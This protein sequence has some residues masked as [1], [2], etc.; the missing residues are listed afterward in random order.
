MELFDKRKVILIRVVFRFHFIIIQRRIM[1]YKWKFLIFITRT[2]GLFWKHNITLMLSDYKCIVISSIHAEWL[3]LISRNITDTYIYIYTF[4]F[5]YKCFKKNTFARL[6][7]VYMF[8][9]IIN[10]FLTRAESF[11]FVMRLIWPA[12]MILILINSKRMRIFFFFYRNF[13]ELRKKRAKYLIIHESRGVYSEEKTGKKIIINIIY[14]FLSDA[15]YR[16]KNKKL[17]LFSETKVH[18]YCLRFVGM[19]KRAGDIIRR[20]VSIVSYPL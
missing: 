15:E 10:R 11:V 19:G 16:K 8:F 6:N 7:S 12:R 4:I 18:V 5:K 9:H 20:T 17:V 1:L 14:S 2:S 3:T 13:S